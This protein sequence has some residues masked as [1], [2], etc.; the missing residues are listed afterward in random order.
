MPSELI[1][2]ILKYLTHPT[3]LSSSALTCK[4]WSLHALELLWYKPNFVQASAWVT[5][6]NV[7]SETRP[8]LFPYTHYIRRIN[9][10]LLASEVKDCHLT[11]LSVCERLERVTLTNCSNLTDKGIMDFLGT[12]PRK[13]LVSV[14]LSDVT[15]VTDA[16][17]KR[18]A[19]TCPH[20]QGLNL[21]M[22]KEGL[23]PFVGVTDSSVIMLAQRC[24]G[25]R[26]IKLNNCVNITDASAIA[27]AE[28]CPALLEIDLMNCAV[29][30]KALYSIFERS[31]EL[32][33]F[34]LNQCAL[35]TDT[36]F[37]QSALAIPP[38]SPSPGQ[39]YYDQLR[40]LDLTAI[41]S[42]TDEA[43]RLIVSMA[44]KIRNLVLNKCLNITDESVL[45]ICH[46]GRYLHYL[47]LGRC[48]RLT[49][50]SIAQLARHC[51]RIRYLDLAYCEELTDRS[52]IELAALP[53]LKRIGLVK[54][55]NITDEAIFALTNQPRIANSLERVHLSYCTNLTMPA[56]MQLVN[57]CDKLTHL[58]LTHVPAFIRP[59][60]QQFRRAPP[61][62]FTP[63]QR[64]VFCVFTG[65]GVRELR[66]YFNSMPP[67]AFDVPSPLTTQQ[68]AAL[69]HNQHYQHAQRQAQRRLQQVQ[70]IQQN[71]QRILYGR[72]TLDTL[73]STFHSTIPIAPVRPTEATIPA[74]VQPG[75]QHQRLADHETDDIDVL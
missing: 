57:F 59:D 40:I 65:R 54:C 22:C 71:Q 64:E 68:Q 50:F 70:V 56:I 2:H 25:L 46:L 37:T 45:A 33:E 67:E 30:N 42:I 23:E 20:L 11:A 31:H 74:R 19:E 18:I 16:S 4:S 35:I 73:S 49:D 39:H 51:T 52:V 17:I 5:F 63:Q 6:C 3:D 53:K 62:D 61:K 34:R 55:T 29:T 66:D 44:P 8:T 21:S 72:G 28:N 75:D 24:T 15:S 32:R 27:L 69:H 36:G 9:L 7:L 14:D 48:H 1:V 60:L 12:K 41:Y 10:S 38:R 47:H 43:V 26:R 13:H 58:S